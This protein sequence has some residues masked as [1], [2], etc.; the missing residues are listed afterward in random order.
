MTQHQYIRQHIS[1]VLFEAAVAELSHTVNAFCANV[2][3][4]VSAAAEPV[5]GRV[6]EEFHNVSSLHVYMKIP[7]VMK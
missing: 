6:S 1:T 5:S 3:Y 2:P 4:T 7:N